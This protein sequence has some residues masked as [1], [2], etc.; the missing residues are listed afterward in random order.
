MIFHARCTF[1]PLI[2]MTKVLQALPALGD[3]HLWMTWEWLTSPLSSKQAAGKLEP[4]TPTQP[5]GWS[6]WE[7]SGKLPG[8]GKKGW[9]LMIIHDA[10]VMETYPICPFG[11]KSWHLPCYDRQSP[12]SMQLWNNQEATPCWTRIPLSQRYPRPGKTGALAWPYMSCFARPIPSPSPLLMLTSFKH[13]RPHL[14]EILG[15]KEATAHGPEASRSIA[16]AQNMHNLLPFSEV[17]PP[18]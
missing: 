10:K 15:K 7:N 14:Q 17:T 18:K 13:Y 4:P 12:S 5:P 11:P 6:G 8:N 16:T 9:D 1:C 3:Y 2:F